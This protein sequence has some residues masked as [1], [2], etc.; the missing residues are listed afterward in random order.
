MQAGEISEI[1]RALEAG[2]EGVRPIGVRV[3]WHDSRGSCNAAGLNS[4]AA[5]AVR[6]HDHVTVDEIPG[7]SAT[8]PDNATAEVIAR[9]I[10]GTH[11]VPA[12]DSQSGV[13]GL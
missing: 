13:H 12:S 3:P 11:D 5:I 1:G 2:S 4:E 9:D 7:I 6:S 8:A 10:A